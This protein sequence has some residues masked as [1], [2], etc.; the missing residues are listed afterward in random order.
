VNLGSQSASSIPTHQNRPHKGPANPS[1][2]LRLLPDTE[3]VR[4][5]IAARRQLF[6]AFVRF[7]STRTSLMR[8]NFFE[9]DEGWPQTHR[10][11]GIE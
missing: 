9:R 10:P 2:T 3:G 4:R 7:F 8:G 1:P 5:E 6:R 11:R